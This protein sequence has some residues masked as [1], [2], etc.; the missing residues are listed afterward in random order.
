[1]MGQV[2]YS[3][4]HATREIHLGEVA[5]WKMGLENLLNHQ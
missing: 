4:V 2:W 1:M 5:P 3:L